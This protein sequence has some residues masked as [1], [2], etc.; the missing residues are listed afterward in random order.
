MC[1]LG[2]CWCLFCTANVC[3]GERNRLPQIEACNA[4]IWFLYQ[5]TLSGSHGRLVKQLWR[6]LCVLVQFGQIVHIPPVRNDLCEWIL[7]GRS[8]LVYN[9]NFILLT[10]RMVYISSSLQVNKNINQNP[11][12]QNISQK[13]QSNLFFSKQFSSR[14]CFK[15]L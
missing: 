13:Y 3:G 5:A 15:V 6:I 7:I 10:I 1:L 2:I 11:D 12:G 4:L 8:L 9:M 14:K